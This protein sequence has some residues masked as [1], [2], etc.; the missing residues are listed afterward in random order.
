M[1]ENKKVYTHIEE[2][3]Y[4][5][6]IYQISKNRSSFV[7]RLVNHT[8]RKLAYK[9]DN[10]FEDLLDDVDRTIKILPHKCRVGLH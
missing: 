9:Y 3:L 6:P 5:W 10:D 4:K 2:D 1:K 7:D 8:Y